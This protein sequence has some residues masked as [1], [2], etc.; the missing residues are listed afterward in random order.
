METLGIAISSLVLAALFFSYRVLNWAYLRPKRV[1]KFL[2]KHGLR[3]NEYRFPYGDSMELIR[4]GERSEP[5]PIGLEDDIKSRVSG[6]VAKTIQTYGNCC[7]I[8]FGPN[9][10]IILSDAELVKEVL[11]KPETYGQVENANPLVKLFF[12]GVV[13]YEGE[14]WIKHRKILNPGFHLENLKLMIPAFKWS[15]E[16]VL[17]KWEEFIMSSDGSAEIDVWPYLQDITSE[18]ISRT[19]F[20]SSYEE[21]KKI[22]QLQR[23]QADYVVEASRSLYIP[24]SQYFPTKRNRRMKEIEREIQV[25]TSAIIDRRIKE[26]KSG[27]PSGSSSSDLL[28]MMLESNFQEIEQHGSNKSFGLT[29]RE[30]VEECKLFYFAGQETTSALLSWTM[31]LLSRY[32][33]WQEEARREVLGVFGKEGTPH[34]EGL[35]HLKI[36]MILLEVLRLYPPVISYGRR[37]KEEI[38]LGRRFRLPAGINISLQ[39]MFLHHSTEIWGED[40]LSFNPERFREGAAKAQ[41]G[42]GIFFPFGWGKRMCIGQV[43]T[44]LEAKIVIAMILQ[45]FCFQLS[46]C[47]VHAPFFSMTM[48][49]QHGAPLILRKL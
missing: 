20:S 18:A 15:C 16:G 2:R 45:K 38:N 17:N 43:F 41:R 25:M 12:T 34:S 40:A 31:V 44:M 10:V 9:P 26:I 5:K 14:K 4:S 6:F 1:E 32:P 24:G 28:R 35:N 11:T 23:E 30:I 48:L 39:I 8:W 36:N 21:G 49:P 3:G 19:A 27:E 29:V 13:S 47:Y 7:F 42:N 22:F 37:A 33:E 46:P